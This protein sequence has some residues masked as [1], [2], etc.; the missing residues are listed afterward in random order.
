MP[1]R[2]TYGNIYQDGRIRIQNNTPVNNFNSQ[3]IT[4][5]FLDVLSLEMERIYSNIDLIYTAIDPTRARGR[6]LDKIGFL[7]GEQREAAVV[8]SDITKTNFNFYID[9]KINWTASQL[10]QEIY[11]AEEINL[12]ETAGYIIKNSNSVPE[13]IVIPAGL[14]VYNRDKTIVYQTLDEIRLT[15]RSDGYG[16]VSAV[17]SG[18]RN[19][20]DTNVLIEHSLL[21]IPELRKIAR[22]IKCTNRF[23]IQNGKYSQTDDE[24]RYRIATSRTAIQSNELSIRRLAL[25][26]PGVRDVMFQ[27]NKFGS[28]T[29]SLIVD[30]VSPL[31][32]EGLLNAVKQVTQAAA[33]YG[34]L[35]FVDRPEYLGVELNFSIRTDPGATQ[36]LALR[37]Q[38]RDSIIQYINNLSIGD[39]IIWNE[40]VSIA[41]GVDGVIDFIPTYFKY[42]KYDIFN[43]LNKEQINLRFVNQRALYNQKWYTDTGLMTCCVA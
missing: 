25:S 41:L 6:D 15:G 37:N 12:L 17:G 22:Y 23:S 18:P 8:A 20:V 32:S 11:T 29:V 9:K 42:G 38:V 27:R 43:K 3:G 13:T 36:I 39:E 7:V 21:Q 16:G 35:I 28:G 2:R 10:I 34:D 31:V 24:Y 5:G 26:V 33:S 40:I 19:N 14:Q 1:T 4:K 30:G